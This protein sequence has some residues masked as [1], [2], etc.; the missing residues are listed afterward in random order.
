MCCG[1]PSGS[2]L[3]T[4]LLLW[5]QYGGLLMF[6]GYVVYDT[7][8]I[9]ELASCGDYDIVGHAVK[10]FT[11]FVAIFVRIAIILAKNRCACC[12]L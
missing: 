5:M 6:V 2:A 1:V 11:D 4:V 7:Q 3:T 9:V 10:L 12:P 8:V